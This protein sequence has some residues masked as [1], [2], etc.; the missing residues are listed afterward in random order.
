MK[1]REKG[2][3]TCSRGMS[4][5]MPAHARGQKALK[6]RVKGKTVKRRSRGVD[7]GTGAMRPGEGRFEKKNRGRKHKTSREA[8]G[9]EQSNSSHDF[10]SWEEQVGKG[11][12]DGGET[13]D[14]P[15]LRQGRVEE[16]SI[17][18]R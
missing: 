5:V 3:E 10:C 15:N 12:R 13:K 1:R 11:G 17:G 14:H 6:N 8:P 2:I 7:G 16:S 18:K 9:T 4:L